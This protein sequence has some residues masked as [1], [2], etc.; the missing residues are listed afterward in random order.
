MQALNITGTLKQTL[1]STMDRVDIPDGPTLAAETEAYREIFNWIRPHEAIGLMRPMDLYLRLQV[2]HVSR[3]SPD[4]R[5][6]GLHRPV[7][8][9]RDARFVCDM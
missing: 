4:A 6:P 5:Q 7:V 9:H 1:S 3:L 2:V 8:A